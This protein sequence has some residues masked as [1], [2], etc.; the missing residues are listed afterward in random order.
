MNSDFICSIPF[1]H[2]NI[3][4]VNLIK[5]KMLRAHFSIKSLYSE[6]YWTLVDKTGMLEDNGYCK[7]KIRFYFPWLIEPSIVFF[8]SEADELVTGILSLLDNKTL[9]D[10]CSN[11]TREPRNI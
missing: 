11:I 9:L 7:S 3:D 5:V 2:K 8:N 10:W 1:N 6:L 4:N